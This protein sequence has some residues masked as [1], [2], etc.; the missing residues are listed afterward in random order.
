[1]PVRVPTLDE[2]DD[3]L[4]NQDATTVALFLRSIAPASPILLRLANMLDPADGSGEKL[5]LHFSYRAKGRPQDT[6]SNEINDAMIYEMVERELAGQTRR[7]V[8]K[9]VGKVATQLKQ[10]DR[11]VRAAHDRARRLAAELAK[12]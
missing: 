7:S 4:D 5:R 3:A 8:K 11:T 6:L 12:N 9:A 10:K 1:M 2:A